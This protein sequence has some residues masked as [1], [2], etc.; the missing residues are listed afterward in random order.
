M[1]DNP[2]QLVFDL[3]HEPSRAR[4]DFVV[5]PA[6]RAAHALVEAWPNWPTRTLAVIGPAG[7]GKSHLGNI[8]AERTIAVVLRPDAVDPARLDGLPS[9]AAVLVEDL[10]RSALDETGLFHLINLTAERGLFALFTSRVPLRSLTVGLRDLA[11]RFSAIPV[12]ELLAPDDLLLTAV[13]AKQFA[14]R[15]IAV[16]PGVIAYLVTRMERSLGAASELVEQ[17][18]LVSLAE[19]RRITRVLAARV[20]GV[21]D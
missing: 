18:D 14:D 5:T 17:L 2:R 6:N 1:S 7:A 11:S 8:W 19:G 21:R 4:E 15:Q 13:M 20:M 12:A 10:D 16:D 3:G 9:G